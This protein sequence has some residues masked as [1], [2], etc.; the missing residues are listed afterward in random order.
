MTQ[1]STQVRQSAARICHEIIHFDK[2]YDAAICGHNLANRRFKR[3]KQLLRFT[4]HFGS[5][6]QG[7]QLPN[8]HVPAFGARR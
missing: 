3:Q 7:L 4:Q 6:M 1:D 5:V 8:V 2:T